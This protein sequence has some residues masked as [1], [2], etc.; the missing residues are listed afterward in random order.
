RGDGA[1]GQYCIII[2]QFDMTIAVTSESW[3]MGKSM[4]AI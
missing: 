4:Q 2:P 1:F 3:D